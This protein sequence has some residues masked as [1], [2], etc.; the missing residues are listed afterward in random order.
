MSTDEIVDEGLRS[1]TEQNAH[2]PRAILTEKQ[3]IEIFN[4]KGRIS[5]SAHQN[6]LL[7]GTSASSVARIYGVSERTVRDIWKGRT[8]CRST[9]NFD[10]NKSAINGIKKPGR[11]KGSRDTKPRKKKSMIHFFRNDQGISGQSCQPAVAPSNKQIS[12]DALCS[13]PFYLM[14][15]VPLDQQV[16][17]HGLCSTARRFSVPDDDFKIDGKDSS[18]ATVGK[19]DTNQVQGDSLDAQLHSWHL[20]PSSLNA[21]ADPFHSDWDFW[22]GS[23]THKH[24]L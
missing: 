12:G 6:Q 4:I 17:G 21:V 9:L 23:K 15:A 22:S 3:A 2:R 14:A 10:S 20:Q 19:L 1:T 16:F 11:P 18:S 8:W 24:P 13:G 5:L 7:T